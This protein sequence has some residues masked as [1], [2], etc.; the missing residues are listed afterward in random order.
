M[1]ANQ[2]KRQ[3]RY[4]DPVEYAEKVLGMTPW[5]RQAEILRAVH[6][7]PRVCVRSGQ[8][9][10]KS[11]GAAAA[12]IHWADTKPDGRVVMTATT[13]P[14]IRNILW[15]E[16]RRMYSR[17]KQNGVWLPEPAQMP[18]IGMQWPDGREIIGFSTKDAEK[19]QGLSGKNML[20]I[21][22]EASGVGEQIFEAIEGNRAG[23]AHILM[24]SNPTQ[25]SGSF[26]E[27]F[28]GGSEFWRTIHVS[29]L[30]AVP[31]SESIPGLATA[32]WAEE[33]LKEWG[34]D[35]PRYQVR[36]LGDF[37]DSSAQTVIPLYLVDLALRRYDET[38]AIGQLEFGVDVARFG[39]DHTVIIGRR[40]N[41][42]FQPVTVSKLDEHAVSERVLHEAMRH[43]S[44]GDPPPLVKVDACGV[45]LGVVSILNQDE[46]VR[47]IGIN[48]ADPSDCDEYFNTRAQ[49]WFGITEWLKGGGA[50]PKNNQLE[51]DLLSPKY[52]FAT[53][54]RMQV[55]KKDEIKKRLGRSPD[56]ADA[57]ALAVFRPA[58]K[59]VHKRSDTAAHRPRRA[60]GYRM[61]KRGF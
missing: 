1:A 5:P 4:T 58:P 3:V 23:G 20:F 9:T 31:Y 37:A 18:G 56:M 60:S 49:L 27:A 46:R 38:P 28:H 13:N 7:H 26:Y 2:T 15:K 61:G 48:S 45:G 6:E 24:L 55:E 52:T 51:S 42:I 34:P 41:K 19:M 8:K 21:V 16:I 32:E 33:K 25:P 14:Q 22:D 40:G 43:H 53:R 17:A 29:S 54:N 50:I 44:K 59:L 11:A 47:C 10:G 35:D 12:A 30:E 36:C 57:L 39:D